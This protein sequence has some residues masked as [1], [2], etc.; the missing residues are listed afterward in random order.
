MP[1]KSVSVIFLCKYFATLFCGH[2]CCVLVFD[3]K[4]SLMNLCS[5]F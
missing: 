1:I 2:K 3:L 4:V 5:M